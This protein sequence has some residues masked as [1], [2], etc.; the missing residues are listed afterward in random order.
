MGDPVMGLG[1]VDTLSSVHGA[2][3]ASDRRGETGLGRFRL[4]HRALPGLD[5]AEVALRM[6][7][8]KNRLYELVLRDQVDE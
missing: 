3:L 4:A 6:G 2:V 7:V 1:A 8:A 5:L